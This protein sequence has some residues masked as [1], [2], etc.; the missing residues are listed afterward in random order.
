M[1]ATLFRLAP[2]AAVDERSAACAP[3][4]WLLVRPKD[5]VRAWLEE[6]PWPTQV[7]FTAA[8]EGEPYALVVTP[9]GPAWVPAAALAQADEGGLV[10]LI[11]PV[12]V[13]GSRV[14]LI[15]QPA[16]PSAD[17][18]ALWWRA[19]LDGDTLLFRRWD[20]VAGA[21]SGPLRR[22]SALAVVE[23][24]EQAEPWGGAGEAR[25]EARPL[26]LAALLLRTEMPA[27]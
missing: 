8:L 9:D 10:H 2:G 1:N 13:V 5:E 20:P 17:A 7:L 12:D 11:A 18:E 23:A 19:G 6:G 3:D 27:T 14:E 24:W 25:G 21:A 15:W 26:L 22:A 16:S 4:P